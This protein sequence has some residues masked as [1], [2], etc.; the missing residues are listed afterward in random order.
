LSRSA[1]SPK[2]VARKVAVLTVLLVFAAVRPALADGYDSVI[3][4][5]VAARDRARESGEARD[6][7]A[8]LDLFA[9][10]VDLR[11]TKE[12]KFEFAEA[13][14]ALEI[15]DEA[16]AAYQDALALE[17]GGKAAER[18]RAF[19]AERA[20]E[21]GFLDVTGPAGTR[22]RVDGRMRAV[23]PLARPLVVLP[24]ARRLQAEAVG[25]LPWQRELNV[26]RGAPRALALDL[27]PEPM[28]APPAPKTIAPPRAEPQK[29]APSSKPL[30]W[31]LPA[32]VAGSGAA[33]AG[34]A[35]TIVTTV[36]ITD[37][38][39]TLEAN[40]VVLRNDGCESTLPSRRSAAQSAADD[41][42]TLEAVRWIS[43]GA[44]VLGTGAA[45]LGAFRL[46]SER[47][48][49]TST[50]D[51]VFHFSSRAVEIEWRGTF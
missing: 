17:L 28:A 34:I 7:Q 36:L 20:A 51:V 8:A 32:L 21:L 12:A 38:R 5:A 13:A 23:L 35:G 18:A 41:I 10:A 43:A 26:D 14:S 19:I 40:C 45:V 16:F 48:P 47:E 29:P 24:G 4:S 39:K 6:W 33:A 46:G 31:G 42:A 11:P 15:Y 30:R 44:A 1:S 22:L 25:F 37:R 49:K 27:E 2:K 9:L 3:G 50:R